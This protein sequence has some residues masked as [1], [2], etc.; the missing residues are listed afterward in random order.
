MS[1]ALTLGLTANGAQPGRTRRRS[2]RPVLRRARTACARGAV[3]RRRAGH[4]ARPGAQVRR[5]GLHHADDDDG[6]AV[7][8]GRAAAREDGPPLQL[9]AA[10][11]TRDAA[12]GSGRRRPGGDSR[13]AAA[14]SCGRWCRSSSTPCSA[15]TATCS[16]RSTRWCANGAPPRRAPHDAAGRRCLPR[17]G[18]GDA[19][20]G[21]RHRHRRRRRAADAA[22]LPPPAGRAHPGESAGAAAPGAAGAAAAGRLVVQLAFWRFEP[23]QAGERV[24]SR[25]SSARGR[26]RARRPAGRAHGLRGPAVPPGACAGTGARRRRRRRFRD[27][28]ARAYRVDADFPVVAVV[29]V[30][31]PELFVAGRV[32][33]AC[34]PGE[35]AVVAAHERAHVAARD[36]LMRAAFAATPLAG[37]R[38]PT[39]RAGLGGRRRGGRRPDGPRRRQRR[40]AGCGA[41]QG[42][43]PGAARRA[44]GR[45]W[46]ARS[47]APAPSSGASDGCSSR[48]PGSG[49]AAWW[50]SLAVAAVLV[51]A[52]SPVL[53]AGLPRG[54][55]RRRVR[56]LIHHADA[57]RSVP[58]R[59]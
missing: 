37:S 7:S 19:G 6:P 14:P 23:A 50:V 12:A 5:R 29:G 27:G 58:K 9:P 41:G 18:L 53:R 36:N 47:S 26:G 48:R 17:P 56:P 49:R 46:P 4:G 25:C 57:P 34:T 40:H 13:A 43:E 52:S 24:G 10:V 1:G 45:R 31:R 16:T 44:A 55:V 33:A 20:R 39:A 22:S 42:G 8:Q 51:A 30:W 21:R 28:A 2:A 11:L 3:A 38:R 59:W 35:I 54:R 32:A 15:R